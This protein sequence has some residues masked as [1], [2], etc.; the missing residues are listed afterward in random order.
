MGVSNRQVP[1]LIRKY[2]CLEPLGGN[3]ASIYLG[4]DTRT[5]RQVVVKLLRP[6]DCAN[7]ELRL[8]F[9]QEAQLACRCLHPNIVTTFDADEEDGQPYIV[10][11]YVRGESLR[12][13]MNRGELTQIPDVVTIA[14]QVARGL[15][16]VHQMGIVHRDIKP[17]N[18]QINDQGQVKLIDFGIARGEN[19]GLTQAWQRLGTPQYMS[20]E[21]LKGEGIGPQSDIYSFGVMFYEMLTGR[22]PYRAQTSDELFAAIL[23]APADP[24][25]LAA[26]GVPE[27]LAEIVLRC[28]E[29]DPS[30]RPATFAEV[31]AALR[32]FAASGITDEGTLIRTA[33]AVGE[34]EPTPRPEAQPTPLPTPG[35]SAGPRRTRT[36]IAAGGVMLA[37]C[38][39]LVWVLLRPR[40]PE[41][42]IEARGGAMVLVPEGVARLGKEGAPAHVDAF[43]IDKTEVSNQAYLEF[44][45][46]TGHAEPPGIREAAPDLPVVN[47]SFDDARAFATWAGKRLPTDAEWEKAARGQEGLVF[48]WG[49]EWKAD[50][51]NLP[52]SPDAAAS[53]RR[54]AVT[55]LPGGASPYGAL[56]M[57]GNVWEWVNHPARLEPGEFDQFAKAH[58]DLDPPLSPEEPAYRIRGGSFQLFLPQ[59]DRQRLSYEFAVM[60][61]RLKGPDLGFRCARDVAK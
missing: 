54:M 27:P 19:S 35:P 14:I 31:E 49:N 13:R 39:V 37:A 4:R 53:G 1:F 12:D 59:E 15:G 8:R 10:M 29:K 22:K 36:L 5:Q 43:Y 11:E 26:K 48:P 42:E 7:E 45:R 9:L 28:L 3:M 57:L 2:E 18:V 52:D 34:R 55:S 50:A 38:L 25:P 24:A 32:P 20:P 30:K 40:G 47:V 46:E 16:Y 56:H 41:P 51:A 33:T 58:P 23:Y 6:E 17:S 21:Q 61:G 60:P 44:C